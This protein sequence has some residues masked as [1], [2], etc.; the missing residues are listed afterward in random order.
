MSEE[1]KNLNPNPSK[2]PEEK[3]IIK[4]GISEG[5]IRRSVPFGD[6]VKK[7]GGTVDMRANK[8]KDSE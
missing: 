1:K 8:K 6:K 5:L 2:K 4:K 7:G 3:V